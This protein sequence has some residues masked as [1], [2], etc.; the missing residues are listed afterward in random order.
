[1]DRQ[2]PLDY[3][4]LLDQLDHKDRL[5]KEVRLVSLASQVSN[6]LDLVLVRYVNWVIVDDARVVAFSYDS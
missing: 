1:M 6:I 3:R 2:E 4:D 5:V